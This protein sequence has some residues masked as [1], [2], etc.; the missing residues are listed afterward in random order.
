MAVRSAGSLILVSEYNELA[1][2]IN[3][4]FS[5][6]NTN[7]EF[8]VVFSGTVATN[9]TECN[10]VFT[11]HSS[12]SGITGTG[13]FALAS[14]ISATDYIV[15]ERDGVYVT[16]GFSLDFVNDEISFTVAID[17]DTV[18]VYNRTLHRIGYGNTGAPVPLLLGEVVEADHINAVIDRT[19]IVLEHVGDATVI[20]RKEDDQVL[21]VDGN[22][23]ETT[24]NDDILSGDIHMNMDALTATESVPETSV[25]TVTDWTTTLIG[26]YSMT[27]TSY[28]QARHFFNSGSELHVDLTLVN[29]NQGL[30]G[31]RTWQWGSTLN[32]MSEIIMDHNSTFDVIGSSFPGTGSNIGFYHLTDQYQSIYD[33]AAFNGEYTDYIT[34]YN[35]DLSISVEAKMVIEPVSNYLKIYFRITLD[36]S[37]L[38]QTIPMNATITVHG[39]NKKTQLLIDNSAS[40][41]IAAPYLEEIA[42]FAQP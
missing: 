2:L 26:E 4:V 30:L 12:D 11:K 1:T 18:V 33:S 13:P 14:A 34:V 39:F 29:N 38:N 3:K 7:L 10:A 31:D 28:D 20:T 27:F 9:A 40:L 24:I 41:S 8:G 32:Q 35:A 17:A 5:D 19:N 36:D 15:V 42:A 37:A 16:T 23:L 21:A 25:V 6:N 22:L